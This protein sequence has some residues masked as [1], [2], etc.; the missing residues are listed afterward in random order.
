MSVHSM[1]V[2]E[3]IHYRLIY[4]CMVSHNFLLKQIFIWSVISIIVS[5]IAEQRNTISLLRAGEPHS[6]FTV[7]TSVCMK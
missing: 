7:H 3:V 1:G 5:N 4:P 6:D 2:F